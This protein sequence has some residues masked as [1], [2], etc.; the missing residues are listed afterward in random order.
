MA[1]IPLREVN[2]TDEHLSRTPDFGRAPAGSEAEARLPRPLLDALDDCHRCRRAAEAMPP[3]VVAILGGTVEQLA[4]AAVEKDALAEAWA[5]V[6]ATM[7]KRVAKRL[8]GGAALTRRQARDERRG[9]ARIERELRRDAALPA[10]FRA[11]PA[12]HFYAL[13]LALGERRRQQ[14]RKLCDLEADA[15]ALAA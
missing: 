5:A 7:L 3:D 1:A 6:E 12:Q 10:S 2:T 15:V 9:W 8:L 14:W 11:N 13:Q 4:Q